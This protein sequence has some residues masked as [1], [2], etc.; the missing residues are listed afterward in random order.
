MSKFRR[1]ADSKLEVFKEYRVNSDCLNTEIVGKSKKEAAKLAALVLHQR[2]VVKSM[3]EDGYLVGVLEKGNTMILLRN[4]KSGKL[5]QKF[6][7]NQFT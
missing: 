6:M 5:P 7:R 1:E 2:G 4:L 3:D